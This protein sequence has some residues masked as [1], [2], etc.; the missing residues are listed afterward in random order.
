MQYYSVGK[1]APTRRQQDDTVNYC[2]QYQTQGRH[3]QHQH[4]CFVESAVK[5]SLDYER[6]RYADNEEYSRRCAAGGERVRNNVDADDSRYGNEYETVENL[7][8]DM[9]AP[10]ERV[11]DR[12]EQQCKNAE[13]EVHRVVAPE[14]R[15]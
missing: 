10:A 9:V 1:V 5:S 11:D 3:R 4:V 13:N 7:P 6:E 14:Q 8:R 2:V 15:L 12:A